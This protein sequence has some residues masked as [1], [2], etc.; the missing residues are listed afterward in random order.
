MTGIST[1][2]SIPDHM[3]QSVSCKL[4][5]VGCIPDPYLSPV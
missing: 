4:S 1:E 3:T 5:G 2:K